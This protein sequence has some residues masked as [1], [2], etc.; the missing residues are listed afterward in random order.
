MDLMLFIQAAKQYNLENKTRDNMQLAH[1]AVLSEGTLT[2][3]F[4]IA[5]L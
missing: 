1:I 3:P 4:T 2:C 5:G